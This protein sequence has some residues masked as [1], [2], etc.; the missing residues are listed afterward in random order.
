MMSMRPSKPRLEALSREATSLQ[1]SQQPVSILYSLGL[2]AGVSLLPPFQSPITSLLSPLKVDHLFTL[3]SWSP[4]R[5]RS[6]GE[7]PNVSG[8]ILG[9]TLHSLESLMTNN[10]RC[11]LSIKRKSTWYI[12]NSLSRPKKKIQSTQS[13]SRLAAPAK[14]AGMNTTQQAASINIVHNS[15]CEIYSIKCHSFWHAE[16]KQHNS[17]TTTSEL[18]AW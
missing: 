11:L 9:V 3:R 2:W 5:V 13:G 18:Q 17:H 15:T 6:L 7:P 8:W 14:M 1:R 10:F 12:C 16:N 4:L